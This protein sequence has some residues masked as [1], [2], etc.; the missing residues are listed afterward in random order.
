V[1]LNWGEEWEW[2]TSITAWEPHE[3]LQWTDQQVPGGPS[4]LVVDWYIATEKGKTVVRGVHSGFG[5]GADWDAMYDALEGGWTY[6]MRSLRHY[7]DRHAGTRRDMV[8]VRRKTRV[9]TGTVWERL[10]S[11][12]GLDMR[13]DRMRFAGEDGVV[14]HARPGERIWGP[15][16]GLNDALLFVEF[17]GGDDAYTVGIW[18][19][20]YG[21]PASRVTAL[22]REM[23]ALG[24]RVLGA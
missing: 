9:P 15:L 17:E 20:T 4:P 11:P 16:A 19:S 14:E 8:H 24:E 10:T 23:D 12:M 6:F 13:D 21:L 1:L 3:H 7:L 18:L 2:W 5:S 22:Q